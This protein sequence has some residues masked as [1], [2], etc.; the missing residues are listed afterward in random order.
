MLEVYIVS[1]LD[2]GDQGMW[3]V[4]EVLGRG[5]WLRKLARSRAAVHSF[6]RHLDRGAG[7]EFLVA[8]VM[9]RRMVL[10]MR[11]GELLRSVL[12]C[13]CVVWWAHATSFVR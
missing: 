12:R 4:V 10:C 9:R 2:E 5:S 1:S 13:L 3:V 11:V 7:F 6:A 8:V